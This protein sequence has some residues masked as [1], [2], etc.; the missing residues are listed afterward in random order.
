MRRR[1]GH[2]SSVAVDNAKVYWANPTYDNGIGPGVVWSTPKEAQDIEDVAD[3]AGGARSIALSASAIFWLDNRGIERAA[4][5]AAIAPDAGGIVVV[6]IPATALAAD[7]KTLFYST[8]DGV[9]ALPAGGAFRA[10]CSLATGLGGPSAIAVDPSCVYVTT[11]DRVWAMPRDASA[12][13]SKLAADQSAQAIT[14]DNTGVYW[15]SATGEIRRVSRAEA[16]P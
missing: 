16:L 3:H 2:I 8:A 11:A 15:A 9:F 1:V 7:D 5:T 12:A 10:V 4:K 6:P 13:P 14:V